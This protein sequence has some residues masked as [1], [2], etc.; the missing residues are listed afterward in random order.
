MGRAMTTRNTCAMSASA[1]AILI[2]L[3]G[4]GTAAAQTADTPVEVAPPQDDATP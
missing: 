2:A 3:A 1:A 4:A